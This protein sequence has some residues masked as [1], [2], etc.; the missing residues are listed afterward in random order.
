[1]NERVPNINEEVPE[2]ENPSE[3]FVDKEQSDESLLSRKLEKEA[4]IA[5]LEDQIK[6]LEYQKMN[7][8]NVDAE[9][10]SLRAELRKIQDEI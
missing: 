5:K 1:M 9:L 6:N 7:G 10:S 3:F 4:M 2:K 8:A